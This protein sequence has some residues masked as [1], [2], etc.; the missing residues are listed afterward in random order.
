VNTAPANT[1][2]PV[3]SYDP[4]VTDILDQTEFVAWLDWIEK[5]SGE[6]PTH[7]LGF[8]LL[9]QSRKTLP[10]FRGDSNA[11]AY[12]FVMHQMQTW[13]PQA[14]I[15]EQ[16][17]PFGSLVAKNLIITI[18]GQTKPTE[19][20]LLTAHLDDT[21]WDSEIAPGANDNATGAATL[22]EA[23]RLL[24]QFE[25]ERTVKLI[26]FTGEEVGLLGSRAFVDQ[27]P[28]LDYQGVINLDMIGWDGDDDRCFDIHVGTLPTSLET[29]SCLVETISSYDLNLTY[30]FITN[31][32]TS[33]S[34]HYAFWEENIGAI[35]LIENAFDN[36][37]P[38]G[39]DGADMNPHYHTVQ[40]TI[41][42]NLTPDYAYEIARA[43]LGT[44]AALAAPSEKCF[45]VSPTIE[46][47]EF[48]TQ[49]VRISWQ[50]VPN[51]DRY[52]VY[53]SSFGCQEGWSLITET[54]ALS[55]VDD[56][57]RSD[58]PYQYQV[59]AVKDN[60]FCVSPPSNCLL[61]GPMPPPIFDQVYFPVV[62][63]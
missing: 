6:E 28:A 5:L 34:D 62:L 29:G 8:P 32:A 59:E 25:F 16:A 30:D 47:S 58:W 44:I 15:E 51:A 48:I 33:A 11:R 9:I 12:D 41:D 54:V 61:I 19:V 35:A 23:A 31:G 27:Y 36:Q 1:Q 43:G 37:I 57:I 7:L 60:G 13:Y 53:R 20:V 2:A 45:S 4:F 42:L 38:G 14:N 46:L 21:S 3:C 22:F 18:P 49:T 50:A 24:R 52:R 40:D 39:C 63:R 17:Y 10:M 26:W 55:S 56:S